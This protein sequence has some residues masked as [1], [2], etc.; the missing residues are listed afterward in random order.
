MNFVS[1]DHGLKNVLDLGNFETLGGVGFGSTSEPI[2]DSKDTTQVV[3]RVTPFSSEPAVIVIEPSDSSTNIEGSANWVKLIWG[4]WY[5]GTVGDDGAFTIE[6]LVFVLF[7][8]NLYCHFTWN[9]WS[10]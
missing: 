2:S 3:R 4:T 7:R 9:D 8:W 1:F 5:L 6:N 10:K